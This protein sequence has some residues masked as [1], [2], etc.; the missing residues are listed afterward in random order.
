MLLTLGLAACGSLERPPVASVDTAN[1][2]ASQGDSAGAARVYENLARDNAEPARS[3]FLLRAAAAWLRAGLPDSAE[4]ALTATAASLSEAEG[5]ERSLLGAEIALDRGDGSAAFA[6]LAALREPTTGPEAIRYLALR[7]RAAF[8][9]GRPTDGV[10][11]EVER[12]KWLPT[13]AARLDSR[14]ALLR[15]LR[16]T[17]A[18]GARLQTE[19]PKDPVVRGWLEVGLIAAT[20][21]DDPGRAAPEINAWSGR[22]PAHPAADVVRAQLVGPPPVI[23]PG[24]VAP[25]V[26][27]LLPLTGPLASAAQSVRDG[28]L[29]AYNRTP[30]ASRPL[31][32]VYDTNATSVGDAIA[33]ASADGAQFIVGP[34]TRE[35][36]LAASDYTGVRPPMLALNFLP[37]ERPAPDNFYQFALSP[38]DE[39]RQVAHKLLAAGERRGIALAPAGDWGDRVLAAFTEELIAGGGQVLA[40]A[41]L[42]PGKSDFSA[43]I[44]EALHLNESKARHRRLE[45][46]L[47]TTLAFEPRR[48]ADVDF[49]FA[50]S[51]PAMA[52]LLRPQL[53][54]HY[55]GD[56]PTYATS[57][58]Y[59]PNPA[60]NADIDGLLFPEMPWMLGT[61]SLSQDVREEAKDGAPG[62]APRRGRLFAFG[63]DAYNLA[64]ALRGGALLE[65]Q[66]LTGTLTL[67]PDKRVRREL[68]WARIKDGHAELLVTAM[69]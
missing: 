38:E 36:L 33:K 6:A 7:E 1:A 35:E 66:G 22:F 58:A 63:F 37:P 42:D 11:A 68:S 14:A 9:S 52:R 8:A 25:H 28:F 18:R 67:G 51:Q 41:G 12:E 17:L 44:T 23:A 53:R 43:A 30:E 49:I 5:F 62:G 32:R 2:L 26:A 61:G 39:A 16:E 54:F 13:A 10:R 57:D 27:L 45:S 64:A 19:P 34:L 65:L 31:I 29:T 55:A 50:A 24:D 21:G 59:D 47:G 3:T 4:T 69:D 46:V 40:R 56:I 48:R 15:E 60:A 20:V